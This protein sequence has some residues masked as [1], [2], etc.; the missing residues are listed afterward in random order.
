M[1]GHEVEVADRTAERTHGGF[2]GRIAGAL[3]LMVAVVALVMPST[4]AADPTPQY[5]RTIGGPGHAEMYPSG[6]DVGPLG[7]VY[8]A[9]TGGDQ[10]AAYDATDHQ[11]WRVGTRGPKTLTEFL[12][13]RDVAYLNGTLYVADTGNGRVVLLDA[14]TGVAST[15]WS[16]FG[17]IMGIS[18]GVSGSGTPIILITQDQKNQVLE[19]TPDGT[20]IRTIGSGPGSGNGQLKAPRDAAT[21]SAGNIYVADYANNRM[22][23]FSPNGTW[24]LNWGQTGT[25]NGWFRRPYGVDVDDSNRVYVA[26]SNNWRIQQ[27]TTAGAYLTSWGSQGTGPAQFMH[28]R[29]VAVG[30]G[31]TPVVYGADLW[32]YRILEF[33]QGGALLT[34]FGGPSPPTGLFNEPSGIAVD[35]DVFVA[36]AV[37][38]RVQQF[39]L[40]GALELVWGHRGWGTDLL[41]FAWPRDIT[42]NQ[43]TGKIWIADTKN[44]RLTEFTR[45]G[46]PTGRSVGNG[47]IGSG[48]GQFYWPLG[49]AS[50]GKDVI[51]ADTNNNRVQRIDSDGL[52]VV[53]NATG[54][55]LPGDVAVSGNTVYVA[56]T[57]NKRVVRLD[58]TTGAVIDSFGAPTL[59]QPGGIAV[60]PVSGDV[61]VA[62]T[63]W[64]RL[65][66]FSPLGVVKQIIGSLGTGPVQFNDPTKLEISNGLLY[67][68]DQW[69][70]RIQ[71]FNLGE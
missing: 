30:P 64:N 37:N 25:R 34:T 65:V 5:V 18:A 66:E 68:T 3:A 32:Q 22:A 60:E 61:W 6:L 53:W 29:R 42:V 57:F 39:S 62:D 41:G 46:T 11:I 31:A 1:T 17:S 7:V 55:K 15:A 26:D 21:D 47:S 56:D 19:Y 20:L 45:N 10:V 38:Q 8:V 12:D 70:D 67:V 51:V 59:H 33:A 14:A 27:F 23:K 40:L 71:V 44:D 24:L 28:L 58:A 4:A 36:D 43:V 48:L 2:S 52:P 35:T 13:P 16:G 54:F 69:N 63:S 9:D 49:I 50:V